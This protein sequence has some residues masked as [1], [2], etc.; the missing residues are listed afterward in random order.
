VAQRDVKFSGAAIECRINAEDPN[1]G[2][3]P[4][5]G[6]V[7]AFCSPGGPGVRID[8]HCYAGYEIS[9]YY[10]SL[11][12]KLIV[13]RR[14]RAEAIVSMRR[15]LDEFVIEGVKTNIPLHRRIFTDRQFIRGDVDTTF[16]ENAFGK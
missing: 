13:H 9:P 7:T 16:I 10:D 14:T 12:A 8:S 1:D 3:R 11:I 6:R 2:F 5:P 4:S 15:A